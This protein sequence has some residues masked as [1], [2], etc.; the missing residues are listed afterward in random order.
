MAVTIL[1]FRMVSQPAEDK[2]VIRKETPIY[3]DNRENEGVTSDNLKLILGE[4]NLDI[5]AEESDLIVIGRAEVNIEN[6]NNLNFAVDTT[7]KGDISDS[8]AVTGIVCVKFISPY[9]EFPPD[10]FSWKS[11]IQPDR[12]Y[13]VFLKKEPEP[14]DS[15]KVIFLDMEAYHSYSFVDIDY[16]T[17]ALLYVDSDYSLLPEVEE[18]LRLMNLQNPQFSD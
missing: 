1:F 2:A 13:L 3:Q 18:L 10:Y 9:F 14:Q 4:V 12:R 11:R 8:E 17:A 5:A 7:L 15:Y 6:H 16:G